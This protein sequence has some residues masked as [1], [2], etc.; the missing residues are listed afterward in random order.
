[1]RQLLFLFL[2]M[3]LSFL[4]ACVQDS[5]EGKELTT[6]SNTE[7]LPTEPEAIVKLYQSYVD[8]NRF[9]A[10]KRLSTES[11]KAWLDTLAQFIYA[12]AEQEVLDSTILQTTFKRIL[13]NQQKDTTL[14]FCLLEDQDGEYK[15]EYQLIRA[16]STWKVDAPENS[17]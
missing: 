8:S 5:K 7:A 13:C 10:A 15:A 2:L 3:G 6:T 16:D 12:N 9:E 17:F 1:M 14:C 4:S 11:G